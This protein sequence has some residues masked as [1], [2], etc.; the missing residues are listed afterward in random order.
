VQALLRV[1]ACGLV[2]TVSFLFHFRRLS[3]S[4]DLKYDAMRDLRDVGAKKI[5]VYSL[6]KVNTLQLPLH[7]S[8]T[9]SCQTVLGDSQLENEA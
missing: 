6:N 2:H 3:V 9:R 1:R 8:L 4:N 5:K 7:C